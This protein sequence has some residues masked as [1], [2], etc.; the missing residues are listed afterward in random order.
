VGGVHKKISKRGNANS[1]FR[2]QR[3][4]NDTTVPSTTVIVT[5]QG[6]WSFYRK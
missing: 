1:W 6:H 5:S 2:V 4:K 3:Q